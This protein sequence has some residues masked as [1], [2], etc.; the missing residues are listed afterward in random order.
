MER[1]PPRADRAPRHLR[2]AQGN[3]RQLFESFGGIAILY[4]I[5]GNPPLMAVSAIG[6]QVAICP[7]RSSFKSFVAALS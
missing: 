6:L 3:G 4:E 5:A 7:N 2:F 1:V